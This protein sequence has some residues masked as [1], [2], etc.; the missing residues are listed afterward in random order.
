MAQTLVLVACYS[1]QSYIH[2]HKIF[3]N[4]FTSRFPWDNT[5]VAMCLVAVVYYGWYVVNCFVGLCRLFSTTFSPTSFFSVSLC[6]CVF[7]LFF[8]CSREVKSCTWWMDSVCCSMLRS[9]VFGQTLYRGF[10]FFIPYTNITSINFRWNCSI[11]VFIFV[12]SHLEF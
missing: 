10:G 12:E 7:L 9:I 8:V 11:I 3:W 6:L 2:L 5:A 4:C 1:R